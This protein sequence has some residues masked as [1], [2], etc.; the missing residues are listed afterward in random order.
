VNTV[1]CGTLRG[2]NV[3]PLKKNEEI[4]ETLE[5]R[6]VGRISLYDVFNPF[7]TTMRGY[8]GKVGLGMYLTFN[9]LTQLLEGAI[10]VEKPEQGILMV[11]KFPARLH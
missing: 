8:Q 10:T 11:M 7:Y 3:E 9:L 2:I 1:D 4:V 6:I 5:D